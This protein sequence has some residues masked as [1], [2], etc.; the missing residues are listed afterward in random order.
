MGSP[1]IFAGAYA[2]LLTAAEQFTDQG[3][4]PATPAAGTQIIY[5]KSAG[6]FL[7]NS[8]GTVTQLAATSVAT[9]TATGTVTSYFPTIASAINAVSSA[10]Y[11]VL[12]SDG[13]LE[14]SVSTANTGRVVTLPAASANVGRRLII[15]KSDSGTGSVTITRAGSDTIN[16]ATTR[17]IAAQYESVTL[18]CSSTSTWD[19]SVSGIATQTLTGI[20]QLVD[21]AVV[22]DTGNGYGSTNTRCRR[23][24]N[25]VV[26]GSAISYVDSAISGAVF[27]VNTTGVY[28]MTWTDRSNATA[29]AVMGF[30]VNAT[31]STD[32][33]AQT[34]PS[35]MRGVQTLT[36]TNTAYTTSSTIRLNATDVIRAMTDNAAQPNSASGVVS[37]T[38]TLVARL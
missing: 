33:D 25:S 23:F 16:G 29:N 38:M 13:Y 30:G 4:D 27:T 35:Q 2:K 31:A 24:T 17:V 10:D 14:I 5:S 15:T 28:N 19:V 37:F 26:T 3:G 1:I 12:T 22:C 21:S 8:S 34:S 20:S 9:P 7:K 32:I 36:S 18:I 11:T 6:L